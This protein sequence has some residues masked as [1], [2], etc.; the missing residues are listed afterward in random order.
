MGIWR[1]LCPN[2]ALGAD[3]TGWSS[4]AGPLTRVT[5]IVGLPVSTGIRYTY[6]SYVITPVMPVTP[7]T[8]Y[9]ASFYLANH[10]GF[11][12]LS[13]TVYLAFTSAGGDDFSQT[14]VVS[15]PK[16]SITR[17]VITGVAPA[18]ATG[19]YLV[20]DALNATFGTGMDITAVRYEEGSVAGAYFDGNTPGATWD[21]T[22]ENSSSTYTPPFLNDGRGMAGRNGTASHTIDF[23]FDSTPGNFLA[24][25]VY[26]PVT[27]T[28]TGWAKRLAP[29]NSG[30][31]A[32]FTKRSTGESSIDVVHNASGFP[33]DWVAYEFPAGWN[34][35]GGVGT[36]GFGDEFPQ[37]TGIPA[38]AQVV[39]AARGRVNGSP[40]E[41]GAYSVWD[42]P[43]IED[44]DLLIPDDG[45]T[46]DG[47]YLTVGHFDGSP[48]STITPAMST[49]YSWGTADRQH[50]VFA[51]DA[52][53]VVAEGST[54]FGGDVP[55][56]LDNVDG[57]ANYA[58]GTRF[59][60]AV[61]GQITH[62]R[63]HFPNTTPSATEPV[64]FGLYR[65]SDA[66]LL[67]S[68]A[69][70]LDATMGR[71]NEVPL[72]T[73]IDVEADVEYAA[74]IWTPLRYVNTSGYPW[75]VT[76]EG[77]TTAASNGWFAS[78]PGGLA[79]PGVL[80]GNA[81]SYFA[82]VVFVAATVANLL[83]ISESL[84]LSDSL[85]RQVSAARAAPVE[86]GLSDTVAVQ[87]RAVTSAEALVLAD[88]VVAG[89]VLAREAS[90]LLV[91]G[92]VAD[93]D[94]LLS[95]LPVDAV[96]LSALLVAV[97]VAAGNSMVSE[98]LTLSDSW[99]RRVSAA[100]AIPVQ[101]GLS[102]SS[103]IQP[104]VSRSTAVA[105]V[106]VLADTVVPRR[107]LAREASALVVVGAV[108]DRGRLLSRLPVAAVV[109]T[110]LL[111][112]GKGIDRGGGDHVTLT[113]TVIAYPGLPVPIII[114]A[115][116]RV[117]MTS[118]PATVRDT[119]TAG[120]SVRRTV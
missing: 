116:H 56:N 34:W 10:T 58:L 100:R 7:G 22:P 49:F 90:A 110:V 107:L 45:G 38:T 68:V 99:G 89:R 114:A 115:P 104:Q 55:V 37:L 39:I 98:S 75:P 84:T 79:N 80:S 47:A 91:T 23:G 59:T 1:N 111:V 72:P 40:A 87:V 32:V 76:S 77:L 78:N 9:T 62:G 6:N 105:E 33:V 41:G 101:V 70:P 83:S 86:V 8:T 57:D 28:A 42:S 3:D 5:D 44:A 46:T 25:V 15:Y 24:V 109:L 102:D 2:P 20:I 117:S 21:G 11:D 48:G 69:F 61:A 94:L 63:W 19:M 81:S 52:A 120:V 106:L 118:V 51:I 64:L 85:G 82:D 96:V 50:V 14:T 30:E 92:D 97:F 108:A 16:D 17:G 67:G 73:P 93:R 54:I 43:W 12:S 27:H 103:S 66:A 65:V 60:P 13:K 88:T 71:W 35:A 18:G 53:G 29:V 74:V 36:A 26:G 31:L 4:G 119:T 95:R 112:A 113:D